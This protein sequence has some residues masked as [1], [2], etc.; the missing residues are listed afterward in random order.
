MTAGANLLG[1]SVVSIEDAEMVSAE[2]QRGKNS[3]A[4]KLPSL[5][6]TGDNKLYYTSSD[7]YIRHTSY[8]IRHTPY[9]KHILLVV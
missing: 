4:G 2:V 7:F 1:N 8:A 3:L 5:L 9:I 6:I